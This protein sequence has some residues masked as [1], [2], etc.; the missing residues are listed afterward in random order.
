[1]NPQVPLNSQKQV[2]KITV[3]GEEFACAETVI[4]FNDL[5]GFKPTEWQIQMIAFF[6]SDAHRNCR[7]MISVPRFGKNTIFESLKK[8]KQK[9]GEVERG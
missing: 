3:N 1:M 8:L 2:H 7:V 6:M 4:S 9:L 5:F